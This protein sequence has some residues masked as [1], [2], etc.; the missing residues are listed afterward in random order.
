M[1]DAVRVTVIAAGFERWEEGRPAASRAPRT[2]A[3]CSGSTTCTRTSSPRPT[4]TTST[5][6]TT[7]ST[8]RPSSASAT[9]TLLAGTPVHALWTG[10]A[11]G[12]QRTVGDGPA[13]GAACPATWRVR[14]LR[15]VHG[16]PRWWWPAAPVPDGAVPWAPGPGRGSPR[17]RRRGGARDRVRPG[18]A[19]RRLRLGGAGVARRGPRRRA[20]GMAGTRGRGAVA[21]AVDTM[22]ALGADRGRG[23]AGAVHRARAATSSPRPTST[24][25][26]TSCGPRCA[27]AT[28]WGRPSLDLPAAVRGQLSRS[29]ASLVVGVD[30]VHDVHPG[31]LLPSGPRRRGAVRRCSSGVRLTRAGHAGAVPRSLATAPPARRRGGARRRR[32]AG[33]SRTPDAT[34]PGCASW[35]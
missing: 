21:R 31:V 2:A 12:D 35:R 24:R 25:S 28:T 4:T 8:S 32:C 14:R 19:D 15:Q 3:R 6:V 30:D 1:T 20:R 17:G 16:P 34:R 23:R 22:R 5:S 18:R 7:S 33:A 13:P 11:D 29:G 27:A 9:D 26:R 10:A